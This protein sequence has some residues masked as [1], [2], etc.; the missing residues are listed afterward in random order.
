MYVH[1]HETYYKI[2][3]MPWYSFVKSMNYIFDQYKCGI[4]S[5]VICIAALC[6]L[7]RNI[8]CD[9]EVVIIILI[10]LHMRKFTYDSGHQ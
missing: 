8:T 10:F 7:Y 9:T 3:E 6:T 5:F 4:L 2:T 1:A